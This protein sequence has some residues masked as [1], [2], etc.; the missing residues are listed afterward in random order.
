M[1]SGMSILCIRSA[2]SPHLHSFFLNFKKKNIFD[3]F[4]EKKSRK[5]FLKSFRPLACNIEGKRKKYFPGEFL[6]HFYIVHQIRFITLFSQKFS[7]V[8]KN[9][10]LLLRAQKGNLSRRNEYSAPVACLTTCLYRASDLP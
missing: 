8:E 6:R 1:F 10:F 3:F 9:S 2:L 7:R 4:L 5:I